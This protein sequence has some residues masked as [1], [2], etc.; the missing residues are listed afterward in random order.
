MDELNLGVRQSL[1]KSTEFDYRQDWKWFKVEGKVQ[2]EAKQ[3]E[4]LA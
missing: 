3:W 2:A 4:H 1:G